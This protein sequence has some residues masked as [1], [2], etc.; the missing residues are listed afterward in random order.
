MTAALV[1][2]SWCVGDGRDDYSGSTSAHKSAPEQIRINDYDQVTVQ[3]VQ[4]PDRD[5]EPYIVVMGTDCDEPVSLHLPFTAAEEL[6]ETLVAL[7]GAV[8]LDIRERA[9]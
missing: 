7:L 2:P 4:D 1:H 5:H 3:L 6:K 8:E 9:S